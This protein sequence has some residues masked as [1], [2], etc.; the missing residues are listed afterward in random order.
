MG[1]RFPHASVTKVASAIAVLVVVEA[2]RCA[3]D[4]EVGPPGATLA[5][6]LSHASGLPTDGATPIAA[7]GTRRIYSNTGIEIAVA[8]AAA[9]SRAT[10]TELVTSRVFEPLGMRETALTGSAASGAIGPTE[11]LC[12]L[13]AELLLPTLLSPQLAATQRTVAYPGLVGVLPGFGRQVPCDWGLGLEVK[14]SKRPHWTGETW[15]SSTVG[16]FGQS[17]G[18]VVADVEAGIAIVTLGDERFGTWSTS[19]WPAFTDAV[20]ASH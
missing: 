14:G 9:A 6:L 20:R 17:G 3:L 10:P 1:E 2:G 19:A 12:A 18:F 15:P 11:D 8:H 5:H 13:A 7:P 4:D 16:H